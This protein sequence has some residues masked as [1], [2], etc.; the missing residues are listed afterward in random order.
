MTSIKLA[1]LLGGLVAARVSGVGSQVGNQ[2]GSYLRQGLLEG[3]FGDDLVA[4]GPDELERQLHDRRHFPMQRI[5]LTTLGLGR[6]LPFLQV[7]GALVLQFLFPDSK[8]A[9]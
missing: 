8:I 6:R 7:L 9:F 5:H 4:Q 2:H 3:D 1:L